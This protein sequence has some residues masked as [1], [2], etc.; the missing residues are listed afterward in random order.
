MTS[1]SLANTKAQTS[2]SSLSFPSG[3]VR[4]YPKLSQKNVPKALCKFGEKVA[5]KW[6]ISGLIGKGGYG[7]IYFAYDITAPKAFA[8]AIKIEP[9]RRKGKTAR[10]MILEQKILLRLQGRSH[11]PLLW[12]SGSTDNFNYIVMQLLSINLN[13]IR[14]QSPFRRLSRPTMG[15]I[16]IQAIAAL[17]DIHQLGYIHRDI[18]PQNM[19]FGLSQASK[20][21]LIIVDY[22]LARR[23]RHSNGR[24]RP[25]REQCGFRGTTTYASLRSHDG[26]DLGPSDDLISL[27]YSAI[28]M[29][30]GELPW[31][32]LRRT[33][34]V[35]FCKMAMQ[36]DDFQAVAKNVG[37]GFRELG[38]A[39]TTMDADDE[40]NYS[41]LQD[42]M[43]DFTDHRKLSDPY[44]WDNDF[45][46]VY[47]EYDL[48][49][50][51]EL[52][53]NEC[54]NAMIV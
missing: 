15:R 18:K 44:D 30:K 33:E 8:V 14:K 10:R 47:R 3:L 32:N 12:G 24:L 26:K 16:V 28:E 31:K 45:Q 37:E 46:E 19:C 43:M 39:V 49:H 2:V 50:M 36:C 48:N 38:R 41:A 4:L 52:H 20:H 29:V 25:L 5:N 35:K 42:I 7:Q 34:D 6:I 9:K 53:Y 40:P 1:T 13:E 21:R 11:V 22:G 54:G 17:R 27:F 23:F 51:Q